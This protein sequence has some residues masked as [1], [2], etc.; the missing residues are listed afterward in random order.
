MLIGV[1]AIVL[2]GFLLFGTDS[3]VT[4]GG[5]RATEVVPVA[6]AAKVGRVS[7][8]LSLRGASKKDLPPESTLGFR[9]QTV[10]SAGE[11]LG[12]WEP[13]G[14][15]A[16]SNEGAARGRTHGTLGLSDGNLLKIPTANSE[17]IFIYGGDT[18]SINF[19][20]AMAF[21]VEKG[22]L[23]YGEDTG[24]LTLEANDRSPARPVVL[25]L[26][27]PELA[28]RKRVRIEADLPD[29]V[30]VVSVAAAVSEGGVRYNFRILVE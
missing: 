1:G 27:R 26:S 12:I 8:D 20:D 30:Y 16:R 23:Q 4:S 3:N 28:V 9:R 13:E 6:P 17:L 5:G 2:V 22:E 10:S 15:F 25:P 14:L 29:G 24:T 11:I 19:L 18:G 21:K 7:A